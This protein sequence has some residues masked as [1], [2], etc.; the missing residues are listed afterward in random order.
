MGSLF[1]TVD[2]ATLDGLLDERFISLIFNV[3]PGDYGPYSWPNSNTWVAPETAPMWIDL[4]PTTLEDAAYCADNGITAFLTAEV[5]EPV[6]PAVPVPS[7]P[8]PVPATPPA[9][10]SGSFLRTTSVVGMLVSSM[11]LFMQ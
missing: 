7:T 2:A 8:A 4:D 9:P 1:D 6:V 11:I 10:T 3:A 5:P